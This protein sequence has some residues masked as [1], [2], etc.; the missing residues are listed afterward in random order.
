MERGLKNPPTTF[1]AL[2]RGINVGGNNL[3][4]MAELRSLCADIGADCAQT[5]LQSGNLVFNAT[6]T[7]SELEATLERAIQKR[8]GIAIPVIV[9][10]ATQWPNYIKNNPFAAAT[11]KEPRF[12]MLGLSKGLPKPDAAEKLRERADNGEQ[13][14][15]IDDT[16]WFHFANGA[17]KSK[18]PALFDRLAGTPVTVRNWNTVLKLNELAQTVLRETCIVK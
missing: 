15:Q 7:A 14:V 12:V 10:S 3:I 9:R 6:S 18:L 4:P 1:I 5:Y 2:L 17:G 8:W 11:K 16:L 13:V